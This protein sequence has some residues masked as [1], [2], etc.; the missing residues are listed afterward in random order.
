MD[1]NVLTYLVQSSRRN[2]YPTADRQNLGLKVQKQTIY[3]LSRYLDGIYVPPTV[4]SEVEKIIHYRRRKSHQSLLENL[5]VDILPKQCV[6][7]T[8]RAAYF[9]QFHT[10]K[11]QKEAARRL[12]DCHVLAEAESAGIQVL[13]SFDGNFIKN[14]EEHVALIRLERPSALWARLGI[15]PGTLSRWAPAP[16]NPTKSQRW[17]KR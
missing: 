10:S 6:G 4:R 1:S 17:R 13:L 9:S 15:P 3:W 8:E 11:S 2:Y 16:D 5:L 12:K 14:L 7:C